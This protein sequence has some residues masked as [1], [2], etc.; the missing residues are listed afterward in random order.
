MLFPTVNVASLGAMIH[1]PVGISRYGALQKDP[2]AYFICGLIL[3]A[4]PL[5]EPSLV[6][7][8]DSW[9]ASIPLGVRFCSWRFLRTGHIDDAR[10]YGELKEFDVLCDTREKNVSPTSFSPRPRSSMP[11]F[12]TVK[13]TSKPD[14]A[15][16][17]DMTQVCASLSSEYYHGSL[18]NLIASAKL[19]LYV[20]P[21]FKLTFS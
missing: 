21:Y 13:L 7:C 18:K 5:E 9:L 10:S 14:E 20:V 2:R 4:P 3:C 19:F 16:V 6:L 11:W 15:S 8:P 17:N 12:I 1:G